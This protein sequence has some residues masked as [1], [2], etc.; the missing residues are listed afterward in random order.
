MEG[1]HHII[2]VCESVMT[3][4]MS[5]ASLTPVESRPS[6]ANTSSHDTGVHQRSLLPSLASRR[7][8]LLRQACW[9]TRFAAA[10]FWEVEKKIAL[11]VPN[12]SEPR[13]KLLRSVTYDVTWERAQ[14]PKPHRDISEPHNTSSREMLASERGL[15]S[16]KSFR[17][18][19][20]HGFSR[21]FHGTSPVAEMPRS[22][23]IGAAGISPLQA[24]GRGSF[25][26]SWRPAPF[27][28]AVAGRDEEAVEINIGSCLRLADSFVDPSFLESSLHAGSVYKDN[29][30]CVVDAFHKLATLHWSASPHMGEGLEGRAWERA[31]PEAVILSDFV[32]N[33]EIQMQE[34]YHLATQLFAACLTLPVRDPAGKNVVGVLVLYL[35]HEADGRRSAVSYLDVARNSALN[36]FSR[37][38]AELLALDRE[39]SR[40]LTSMQESAVSLSSEAQKRALRLWRRVRVLV[41]TGWF[42]S[43]R[44][45]EGPLPDAAEA[46]QVTWSTRMRVRLQHYAAKWCGQAASQPP[47]RATWTAGAWTLVGAFLG[48]IVPSALEKFY[49]HDATNLVLMLGSF[50]A[51]ATL[52]FGAPASPFAQPRMVLLGHLQ[53]ALIAVLL[54]Y[55]VI[56]EHTHFATAFIPQWVAAALVPAV[57][58]TSMALTGFIN[59]PAAACAF[60][61]TTGNETIK[62]AGWWYL[63]VPLLG[64]SLMI[65]VALIVNNL[66]SNRRYP[67]F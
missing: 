3:T 59:P 1:K 46:K 60:I 28:L 67:N 51:L 36:T 50:G 65:L 11:V 16:F 34:R 66:S 38:V 15:G 27:R 35:P 10:E 42:R 47:P 23:S 26:S 17:D 44:W 49:F 9:S 7:A 8:D 41:Q 57:S 13:E 54:D 58:I 19:S 39:W 56:S 31:Q 30:V 12:R 63:L 18:M 25:R 61:Y 55:L 53:S 52:L 6:T 40:G 5:S 43:V 22:N 48:L 37:Q 45:Q 29:D 64:S 2:K 21:S 4:A 32:A 62:E 33:P 14:E 20:N 24:A